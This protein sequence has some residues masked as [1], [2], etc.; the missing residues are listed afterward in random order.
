MVEKKANIDL[1]FRKGLD[2]L[3]ILPPVGTWNNI[4]PVIRKRQKPYML[5]RSAALIA[6]L[7][8]ISFLAYK[9][10]REIS[11]SLQNSFIVRDEESARTRID[12][13][14]PVIIRQEAVVF[15][16]SESHVRTTVPGIPEP[17]A[18]TVRESNQEIIVVPVSP[19]S[20]Q[21]FNLAGHADN[22]MIRIADYQPV[23]DYS[24]PY[25]VIE[26][27]P[28]NAAGNGKARWSLSAIASPSYYL[29]SENGTDDI[30][31]Q[32]NSYEK[33][34][35]SY[36]GGI[37]FAYKINDRLSV[38]SGL[39]YTSVGQEIENIYSYAGFRPFDNTKNHHNFEV[40]TS[41]GMI[42]T[43]NRDVFLL[44]NGGERVITKFTNDVF[45]PAK[46]SLLYL[47]NTLH[48]TFSYLEMPLILRYKLIDKDLDFN[49]I[50]GFSYN[51]LINNSV[52]TYV[53][54]S[55]YQVGETDGLNPLM[56]SSSLG[57]GLEYNLSRKISLNLEPT[58]RYYLNPFSQ[59][60]AV[61]THPYSFGL[62][63]GLSYRF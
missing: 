56:V 60:Q 23:K 34:R 8:S 45:D 2:D 48:Q 16:Q 63:S 28:G 51:M 13:F 41:G 12:N 30:S 47:N 38:Q 11:T 10:S 3:E 59:T 50:G 31:G 46:A 14:N 37:G 32:I 40:L 52:Y 39:Y 26:V 27:I 61:K 62:F 29:K 33:P 43:D 4:Y 6:V 5:L 1:L 35:M 55:K 54:G 18:V 57:M 7:I 22:N 44:D 15:N 36:S 25:G 53:N 9:W 42:Y 20:Y 19:N 24:E 21:G 17:E 49:L 58:F